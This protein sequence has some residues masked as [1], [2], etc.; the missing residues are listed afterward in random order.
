MDN[1]Y[2]GKD[3]GKCRVKGKEQGPGSHPEVEK[4]DFTT[5]GVEQVASLLSTSASS[6]LRSE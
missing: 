6:S 5:G 2:L 4:H 1:G 3:P